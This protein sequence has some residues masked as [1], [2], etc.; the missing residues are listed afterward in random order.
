MGSL[1]R[2]PDAITEHNVSMATTAAAWLDTLVVTLASGNIAPFHA[3]A[4]QQRL[5]TTPFDAMLSAIDRARPHIDQP[6]EIALYQRWI[7]ANTGTSPILH[8]AWF[9]LGVLFAATGDQAN[10]AIAY[11]NALTLKPD[12]YEAA[13]NLGLLLERSGQPEQALDIWKRATQPDDV[14]LALEIQQG[15][16]LEKLGRFEEA[17]KILRR[18]LLTNPDQPDVIHH[19]IHIRQKTCLWPVALPNMPGLSAAELLRRS[20]PLGILALT[21]DIELQREA[22]AAWVHRKTAPAPVRLAPSAP[23][24]HQRI[25]IGYMSSA[26]A[27][28]HPTSAAMP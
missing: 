22:A 28:C 7:D 5:R 15:R 24:S 27:T 26:S 16:L 18:A 17:E 8:A 23:Y 6:T 19:W 11:G 10:A 25:R 13:I 9:N 2:I 3:E 21:D 1:K 20:G 14:R 4:M 12:M